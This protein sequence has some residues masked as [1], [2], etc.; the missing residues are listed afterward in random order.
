M[1]NLSEYF[2]KPFVVKPAQEDHNVIRHQQESEEEAKCAARRRCKIEWDDDE[3]LCVNC[4]RWY[5]ADC[6]NLGNMMKEELKNV[7]F[8]CARC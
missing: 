5:H 2:Q 1:Y 8:T 4:E 6:V 3:L 7:Y